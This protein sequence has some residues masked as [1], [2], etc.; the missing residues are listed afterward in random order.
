MTPQPA[1]R[2]CLRVPGHLLKGEA[3]RRHRCEPVVSPV[4]LSVG[5]SEPEGTPEAGDTEMCPP[6]SSELSSLPPRLSP[7]PCPSSAAFP[8]SWG[9]CC[10]F[11]PLLGILLPSLPPNVPPSTPRADGFNPH[12]RSVAAQDSP[13]VFPRFVF[14]SKERDVSLLVLPTLL[15]VPV[16]WLCPRAVSPKAL[17]SRQVWERHRAA[18]F[19]FLLTPRQ[20]VATSSQHACIL[21]FPTSSSCPTTHG[22]R[23][24]GRSRPPA[25]PPLL[26]MRGTLACSQKP[27]NWSRGAGSLLESEA[28]RRD[29]ERT[30]SRAGICPLLIRVHIRILQE[31]TKVLQP[32]CKAN[33][34]GAVLSGGSILRLPTGFFPLQLHLSAIKKIPSSGDGWGRGENQA[35]Q[36][37]KVSPQSQ[38]LCAGPR[39]MPIL[40]MARGQCAYGISTLIKKNISREFY[41]NS[42]VRGNINCSVHK[43]VQHSNITE[44]YLF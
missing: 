26:S 29:G 2:D 25:S 19:V 32:L 22:S 38:E 1:V 12:P 35:P 16:L 42:C 23:R 39:T 21:L 30:L 28:G 37:A 10:N 36:R 41:W 15:G 6:L 27:K 24:L 13:L 34:H 43:T 33:T 5:P 11:H 17:D 3:A 20:Q 8:S 14:I 44:K 7:F 9:C 18:G 31:A 40:Y 4:L